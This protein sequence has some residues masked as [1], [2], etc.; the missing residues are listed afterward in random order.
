MLI[1]L[2]SLNYFVNIYMISYLDEKRKIVICDQIK[3][4]ITNHLNGELHVTI[5]TAYLRKL[6][7]KFRMNI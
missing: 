2:K 6:I 1:N 7:K 4:T 5:V 3:A